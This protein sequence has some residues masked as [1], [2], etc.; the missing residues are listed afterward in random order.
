MELR[1]RKLNTHEKY[2]CSVKDVKNLFSDANVSVHFGFHSRNFGFNSQ[3]RKKP[4][5]K[6][7]VIASASVSKQDL[8]GYGAVPFEHKYFISFYVISD[9]AYGSKNEETFVESCLPLLYRW[10][11]DMS[12]LPDISPRGV[13]NFLIEWVDGNFIT[14]A[15]RYH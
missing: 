9:P 5:I 10:H 3:D 14:H 8:A 13:E 2:A 6:G 1:V 7:T 15:Y 12:A 4:K 11:Q